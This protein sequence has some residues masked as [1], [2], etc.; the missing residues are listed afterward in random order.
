MLIANDKIIALIGFKESTL[1]QE[2]EY[3]VKSEHKNDTIII[4]P[5]EFLQLSN[6]NQYQYIV[7]FTLDQGQ[8]T[9]IIN[10]VE[11]ENLDCARYI[12]DTVVCYDKNIESVIGRGTFV[13]P[14]S[15]ILLNAKIGKYCIL[16]GQVGIAGHL[17]IADGTVLGAKS[18]V[19]SNIKKE[20]QK[21]FGSPA[22]DYG[23]SIKASIVY[24]KLPQLYKTVTELERKIN[25]K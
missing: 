8:R 7:A 11:Q 13:A 18:G 9:Q 20:N 5:D 21:L 14:Y 23:E 15:T 6:R 12:H 10:V 16:A 17:T 3:F 25:E 4:T 24:K 1:T 22:F 19:N 2:A